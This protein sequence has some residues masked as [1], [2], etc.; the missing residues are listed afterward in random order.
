MIVDDDAAIATM[1]RIRL[2]LEGWQV[3]V[4][5]NGRVA[6]DAA[7]ADPPDLV[8]L[9]MM[10]PVLD[11][12]GCLEAL[13]AAEATRELPVVVLTNSG[14]LDGRRA[15]ARQ[16]GATTWLTKSQTLPGGLVEVVR[17]QLGG[18]L[19]REPRPAPSAAGP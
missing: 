3:E 7:L 17:G 12:I 14:G 8:V 1:Y 16:L 18:R 4:C 15:R 2:E 13:R 10:M 19:S 9:D 6:L 5:E 11:G